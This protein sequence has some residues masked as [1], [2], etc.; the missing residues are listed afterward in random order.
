MMSLD[1]CYEESI[2]LAWRIR[3]MCRTHPDLGQLTSAQ[4]LFLLYLVLYRLH[5]EHVRILKLK[6]DEHQGAFEAPPFISQLG[7]QVQTVKKYIFRYI[8]F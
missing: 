8:Y 3:T 7:E 1:F 6:Q 4:S 2:Y 5:F